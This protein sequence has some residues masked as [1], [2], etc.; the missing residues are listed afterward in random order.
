MPS[1]HLE[2]VVTCHRSPH[3]GAGSHPPQGAKAA[4]LAARL[5]CFAPCNP[6]A[7]PAPRWG[8]CSARA[9]QEGTG[10]GHTARSPGHRVSETCRR[11]GRES[12]A[13]AGRVPRTPCQARC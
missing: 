5:G 8:L 9:Q 2:T 12:T 13:I 6:S 11:G 3:L 10:G 1:K 4:A 7:G